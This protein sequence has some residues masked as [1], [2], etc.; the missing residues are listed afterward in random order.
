MKVE[1][2]E[3]L[4]SSRSLGQVFRH[5]CLRKESCIPSGNVSR[6]TI[7][8]YI[9]IPDFSVICELLCLVTQLL[10]RFMYT[11]YRNEEAEKSLQSQAK[12]VRL[13]RQVY[14]YNIHHCS[15]NVRPVDS[16]KIRLLR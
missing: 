11:S 14:T 16:V 3:F 5:I 8:L 2:Q 4:V 7:H 15:V 1:L 13:R 6:E 9:M 12:D 10:N